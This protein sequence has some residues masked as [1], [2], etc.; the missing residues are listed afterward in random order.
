MKMMYMATTSVVFIIVTLFES[1]KIAYM[2]IEI[3]RHFAVFR[4]PGFIFDFVFKY[5][6][7]ESSDNA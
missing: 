1:G 4:Y 7:K 2:I 6:S 5:D 3:T